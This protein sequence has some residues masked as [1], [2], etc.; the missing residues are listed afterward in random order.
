MAGNQEG[1]F[2]WEPREK[3]GSYAQWGNGSLSFDTNGVKYAYVV[4]TGENIG[5][6]VARY[7]K[8]NSTSLLR[9]QFMSY[10]NKWLNIDH[11]ANYYNVHINGANV[12]DPGSDFIY[13]G[14]YI[15]YYYLSNSQVEAVLLASGKL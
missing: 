2:A 4:K 12:N 8:T 15:Y 13:R 6:D 1:D 5:M 3:T 11:T 7:H 9:Y 14:T 10:T